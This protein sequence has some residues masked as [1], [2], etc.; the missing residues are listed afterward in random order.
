MDRGDQGYDRQYPEGIEDKIGCIP[1]FECHIEM[2]DTRPSKV[3]FYPVARANIPEVQRQLDELLR[4]GIIEE[5]ATVFINPLVVVK[6][7]SGEIRT[8]LDARGLNE[9]MA[10]DQEQPIPIDELLTE[11]EQSEIYSKIDI[12]KAFS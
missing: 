6:K 3:P 8:C 7:S 11:V 5:A 9:R 4:L 2:K 1:N 12:A 10:S